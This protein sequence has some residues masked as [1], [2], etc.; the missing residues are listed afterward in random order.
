MTQTALDWNTQ[1]YPSKSAAIDAW[2][3][4]L[5]EVYGNFSFDSFKPD[6]FSLSVG[7]DVTVSGIKVGSVS[8]VGLEN[9]DAL[10]GFTVDGKYALGSDT[11]AHIRTGTLDFVLLK[12]IDAQF[13]LSSRVFS[14]WGLPDLMFGIVMIVYAIAA[15]GPCIASLRYN[16]RR[17]QR[18]LRKG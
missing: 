5:Q 17:L 2:V 15:N 10:V 11:T 18:I 14:P 16:R 9:G 3:S 13:W 12:P 6:G 4:K 1:L 7:N 8:S